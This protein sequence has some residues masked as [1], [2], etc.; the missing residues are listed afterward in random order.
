MDLGLKGK[1]ALVTGGS[2]GIGKATATSLAKEGAKVV[3]CARRLEILKAAAVD[4]EGITQGEVM[5]V[6]A[7]SLIHI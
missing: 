3:I 7:L 2:D 6:Q 4:I 1:I 5:P